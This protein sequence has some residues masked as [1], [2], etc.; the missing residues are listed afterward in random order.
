MLTFAAA[1]RGGVA[2]AVPGGHA[3]GAVAVVADAAG[4]C[5]M[6]K[7]TCRNHIFEEEE[8]RGEKGR[9]S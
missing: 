8:G 6:Q 2:E 3:A 4:S 5:C 9:I 7:Q 1:G